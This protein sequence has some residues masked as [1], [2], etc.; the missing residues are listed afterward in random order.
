MAI[1]QGAIVKIVTRHKTLRVGQRGFCLHIAVSN[2]A[3]LFNYFNQPGNPTSHFYVRSTG[4]TDGMADFE[5]YVDTKYQAPANLQGNP[6][7]IS[8]ET[9]GGVGDD[10][11]NPWPATMAKRIAWILAECHR[12]HGI[13]LIA[14]PN[15][16]PASMGVGYHRLGVDPWRVDG[17]ELW[18]SSYGKV[19]P[20]DARIAQVPAIITLARQMAGMTTGDDVALTPAQEAA[21]A[22]AGWLADQFAQGAQFETD[23]D[24]IAEIKTAVAALQSAQ[25]NGLTALGA[26]VAAVA[27]ALDAIQGSISQLSTAV[28]GIWGVQLTN[29]ETP[30]GGDT[31]STASHLVYGP[32]HVAAR[33]QPHLDEIK[34]AIAALAAAHEPPPLD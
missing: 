13:P 16:L 26:D 6:T 11:N 25:S 10:L 2:G 8:L 1:L 24:G 23:L 17:G 4:N 21:I 15:S 30:E 5:Q 19:C 29:P 20:G 9:Q 28:S 33:L 14:M 12:I 22:K 32:T 31:I 27:A 3:S 34:A 18:S 7:L